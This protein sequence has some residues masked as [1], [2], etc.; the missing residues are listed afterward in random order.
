MVVHPKQRLLRAMRVL[1]PPVLLGLVASWV[2]TCREATGSSVSALQALDQD[3]V[4]TAKL[5]CPFTCVQ[6]DTCVAPCDG[7]CRAVCSGAFHVDPCQTLCNSWCGDPRN[8]AESRRGSGT[9]TFAVAW[10][11]AVTSRIVTDGARAR[12]AAERLRV[13][14]VRGIRS[15]VP[16]T[17]FAV[18]ALRLALRR[19]APRPVGEQMAA[20]GA[21]GNVR[22]LHAWEARSR[23]L[24][25]EGASPVWLAGCESARPGGSTITGEPP[26]RFQHSK[27][28]NH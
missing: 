1:A 5:Q 28:K 4:L 22:S 18:E 25:A 21:D 17:R 27:E 19:A 6:I 9:G 24:A 11:C 23:G 20:D 14:V 12:L 16:R 10:Y 13:L 2:A 15:Q 3:C 26:S 8:A 7:N